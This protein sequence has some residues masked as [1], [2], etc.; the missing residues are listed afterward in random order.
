LT[1]RSFL[2]RGSPRCTLE[3]YLPLVPGKRDCCPP[4]FSRDGRFF[5]APPGPMF[6]HSQSCRY[7]SPPPAG[8]LRNWLV[9]SFSHNSGLP[10][11]HVFSG[12]P[13][14]F[15]ACNLFPPPHTRV[16]TRTFR[17]KYSGG[18]IADPSCPTCFLCSS[19]PMTSHAHHISASEYVYSPPFSFL[20][21]PSPLP[22]PL[23]SDCR[24][25]ALGTPSVFPK[26]SFLKAVF[27][28]LCRM[29]PHPSCLFCTF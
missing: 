20:R 28:C 3:I 13:H 23:C 16:P 5:S 24:W 7:T 8:C 29:A 4:S 11:A 9:I 10:T 21:D 17:K 1:E 18:G 12:P 15:L 19:N 2:L 27:L 6:A 26:L 14:S 25:V 22:F